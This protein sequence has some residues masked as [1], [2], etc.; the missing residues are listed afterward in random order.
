[1]R[2]INNP[3]QENSGETGWNW[4]NSQAVVSHRSYHELFDLPVVEMDE[5]SQL[6]ANMEMLRDLQGR[7]TFLMR[8]IRY[9]MKV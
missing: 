7:L 5:L 3:T 4:S 9:V 8:E 1:M 2:I 6:T